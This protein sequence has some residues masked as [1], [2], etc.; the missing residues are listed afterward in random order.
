MTGIEGGSTWGIWGAYAAIVAFLLL[1]VL[2]LARTVILYS[3]LMI[4]PI[5]RLLR[6]IPAVARRLDELEGKARRTSGDGG[7][8]AGR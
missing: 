4:L 8:H 7:E 5:G 1:L 2:V 3:L 6:W